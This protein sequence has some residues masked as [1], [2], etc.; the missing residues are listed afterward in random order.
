MILSDTL[1]QPLAL[2]IYMLL[3]AIFGII[4]M[5]NAFLCSFIIK[6]NIYRHI[7]QSLY[8]LLYGLTFF[9]VTLSKFSYNLKI[10]HILI[11]VFFTVLTSLALFLPIKKHRDRIMTRCDALR[12]RV[13][14]SK[15]ARKFKK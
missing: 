8:A 9:L 1:N 6:N 15:L 3:G 2:A 7:S 14:Q 5:L 12:S 10:Y 11:C 4:Y 13:A